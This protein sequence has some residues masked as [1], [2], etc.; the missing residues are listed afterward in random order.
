LQVLEEDSLPKKICTECC[1]SLEDY[2]KYKDTVLD[3]QEKLT[4]IVRN[5]ERSL[6]ASACEALSNAHS[7]K[8]RRNV[9]EAEIQR[10]KAT[11]QAES[12]DQRKILS[13]DHSPAIIYSVDEG[14]DI[15]SPD[16]NR[17]VADSPEVIT[18]A[19]ENV[20]I[21]EECN[22]TESKTLINVCS[23]SSKNQ[24]NED[25]VSCGS[26]TKLSGCESQTKRCE[27]SKSY[28]LII[29]SPSKNNPSTSS[30]SPVALVVPKDRQKDV[31]E[32]GLDIKCGLCGFLPL[33]KKDIKSHHSA[34][35]DLLKYPSPVYGCPECPRI[36]EN[37][38]AMRIHL[39]R[40]KQDDRFKCKECYKSYAFENQLKCH[41]LAAHN[42]NGKAFSCKICGKRFS[43]K[44]SLVAHMTSKH[45]VSSEEKNVLDETKSSE[46]TEI[47]AAE[48]VNIN[49]K[50]E[51][52]SSKSIRFGTS[53]RNSKNF[54]VQNDMIS[55]NI[56][57]SEPPEPFENS[58]EDNQE[59]ETK[60]K[61]AVTCDSLS[62]ARSTLSPS[63]ACGATSAAQSDSSTKLEGKSEKDEGVWKC[64]YCDKILQSES[65]Y[66][67]HIKKHRGKRFHCDYCQ[68]IFTQ[69]VS[70]T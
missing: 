27:I 68:A 32:S 17:S 35:H 25:E 19:E 59:S 51:P 63:K 16:S 62:N 45:P 13:P 57:D 67:I 21:Q 42:P 4:S 26:S 1:S 5:L 36:T 40:H 11:V 69:A 37:F 15:N 29:P 30:A 22:V 61:C 39:Y 66:R 55:D 53:E 23:V 47:I 38:N 28:Q 10:E 31:Q 58:H 14:D 54:V 49:K 44:C 7:L 50:E 64:E 8:R 48:V 6:E 24:S 41:V 18:Q 9:V 3:A 12:S 43:A 60:T 2:S 46:N 70:N 34:D 33:E 56:S 65:G 20:Q 52:C